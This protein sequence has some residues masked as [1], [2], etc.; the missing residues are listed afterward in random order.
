VS[1]E[2]AMKVDQKKGNKKPNGKSLETL[3][4]YL[5][6]AKADKIRFKAVVGLTSV[7]DIDI[8]V[9][10]TQRHNALVAIRWQV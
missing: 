5:N 9:Q 1:S 7:F 8:P 6:I 2:K 3:S 10:N 4:L